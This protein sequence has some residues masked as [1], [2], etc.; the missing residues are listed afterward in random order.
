MTKPVSP[1]LAPEADP[2]VIASIT[3]LL[4]R[5]FRES[6]NVQDLERRLSQKGYVMQAGY[7]ATA[8]HGKLICPLTQLGFVSGA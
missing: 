4:A 6:R 5:D 2:M 8:P 7:L 1:T 3:G